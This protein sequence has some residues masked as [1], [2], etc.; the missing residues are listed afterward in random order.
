MKEIFEKLTERL[1]DSSFWTASTF[2]DDGYSN[3]DSE[4]V[5]DLYKALE[6][7]EQLA[8]E[9]QQ[10][11][12]YQFV[13]LHANILKRMGIDISSKW[14]D[15]KQQAE[16]LEKAYLRGRQDEK[17]ASNGGWIPC[18]ERLPEIRQIVLASV[19]FSNSG[20]NDGIPVII[21][22]YCGE[23]WW[24]DGTILAWQPLPAP[25]VQK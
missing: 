11:Q 22:R 13:L 3:D 21:S 23:D 2:D 24:Q 20:V 15:A 1:H 25:Y 7:V 19:S 6:I 17:E 14:E 16:A 4:E 12:A 5:I 18:S 8:E 10:D 9:V